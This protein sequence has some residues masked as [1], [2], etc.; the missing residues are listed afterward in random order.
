MRSIVKY[1]PTWPRSFTP[2]TQ[3]RRELVAKMKLIPNRSLLKDKR[4]AFCDDSIV[5]G[6]QLRDNVKDLLEGGVKEIHV[7]ISCPPLIY[8]CPFISFTSSKSEMELI[9]RRVIADLEG[10]DPAAH[11]DEYATTDSPRYNEMVEQIRRRLGLT[12]LRFSTIEDIVDAIG[13]PKERICTHCFDGSSY[14]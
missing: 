3:E 12:S 8:A 6:T 7:R 2:S 13:L 10:G 14:F 4:I 5:R 9:T 11:L 1:T